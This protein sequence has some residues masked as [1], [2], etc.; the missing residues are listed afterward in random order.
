MAR[1]EPIKHWP[2]SMLYHA[3]NGRI[4]C[5][6]PRGLIP[7]DPYSL[8][9]LRRPSPEETRRWGTGVVPRMVMDVTNIVK[10][11]MDKGL[12]AAIRNRTLIVAPWNAYLVLHLPDDRVVV[13]YRITSELPRLD[14][15]AATQVAIAA[16]Y[17]VG[18]WAV[19]LVR[20]FQG[21]DWHFSPPRFG[22][23]SGQWPETG[24]PLS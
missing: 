7:A 5:A 1:Y 20:P 4:Y 15:A 3:S 12:D 14:Q 18:G 9:A 21:E 13:A 6:A 19:E 11:A 16:G 8:A 10:T 22:D 2:G 23:V 24:A 17:D